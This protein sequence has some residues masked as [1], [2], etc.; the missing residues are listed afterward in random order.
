MSGFLDKLGQNFLVATFIPSLGFVLISI[1]IFLPIFPPQIAQTLVFSLNESI[2]GNAL[3]LFVLTLLLGYTLFGLNTFL[4]KLV[5][6]YYFLNRSTV[7]RRRQ[8]QKAQKRLKQI[9]RLDNLIN[10]L[11]ERADSDSRLQTFIEQLKNINFGYKAQ[12]RLDYPTQIES[13]LP[14]RFGNILRAAETYPNEHYGLEAVLMWPRLIYVMPS[15]Y[16]G[17]VDQSNNGLAFVVNSMFLSII[18]VLLCTLGS[19][20]Q[21]SVKELALMQVSNPVFPACELEILKM[22]T[23]EAQ[24]SVEKA[25]MCPLYFLPLR[26][27][28]AAQK[29]YAQRGWLYLLGSLGFVGVSFFFYNASLLAARQYGNMIRSAYDLFRFDLLRQLRLPLPATSREEFITWELWTEFVALGD[30][31]GELTAFTYAFAPDEAK[32]ISF[33]SELSFGSLSDDEEE[34]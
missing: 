12:Y 18:L 31:G 28:Q 25:V 16:F 17:K 11:Y 5:E 26:V 32:T 21:F 9:E 30:A 29:E 23:D 4:Y 10:N 7:W 3:L 15:S 19:L 6:G 24:A 27:D 34:E 14:T 20:Y 13:I 8:Q 22:L 1:F 33:E 2:A